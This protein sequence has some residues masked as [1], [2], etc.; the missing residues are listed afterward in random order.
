[1]RAE[2]FSQELSPEEEDEQ[3]IQ[4]KDQEKESLEQGEESTA[5]EAAKNEELESLK[6][7]A[8]ALEKEIPHS[9]TYLEEEK[10]TKELTELEAKI[11]QLEG[12]SSKTSSQVSAGEPAETFFR[13]EAEGTGEREREKE[14][15]MERP[16]VEEE[17]QKREKGQE[18]EESKEEK[19]A[20]LEKLLSQSR[21]EYAKYKEAVGKPKT[22]KE[23][24]ELEEFKQ[25]YYEAR[26]N[27]LEEKMREMKEKELG[28]EE[29]KKEILNLIL[30][31]QSKL[32]EERQRFETPK[33]QV[34]NKVFNNKVMRAYLKI[35]RKYRWV[36]MAALG[37]ATLLGGGAG[38]AAAGTYFG[39]KLSRYAIGALTSAG[40]MKGVEAFEKYYGTKLG[41][42][43]DEKVSTEIEAQGEISN[44][45]EQLINKT[46]EHLEKVYKFK[47]K[48]N[49]AKG[50]AGV[51]G[52]LAGYEVTD[53]LGGGV[54]E[55]AMGAHAETLHQTAAAKEA[56]EAKASYVETIKPG[57]S[58]WK[59][60][61]RALSHKMGSGWEHL[62]QAQKTY[63]IDAMK[64]KVAS[65][66]D[67]F[68]LHTQNID[69][70]HPGEKIDFSSVLNNKDSFQGI[71]EK[72]E[73]LSFDQ[74]VHI[75]S[76][77]D[78][79]EEVPMGDGSKVVF[80]NFESVHGNFGV[81]F[82]DTN[83]DGVAD[84]ALLASKGEVIGRIPFEGDPHNLED[85]ANF[86][87]N[88]RHQAEIFASQYPPEVLNDPTILK[89]VLHNP[90][91][92]P[93]LESLANVSHT[94]IRGA[95]MDYQQTGGHLELLRDA[96]GN[97]DPDQIKV[98]D[99][100]KG[101]PDKIQDALTFSKKLTGMAV[102]KK[103]AWTEL[104]LD[105]VK[106]K[107][108]VKAIDPNINPDKIIDS[109]THWEGNNLVMKIDRKFWFDKTVKISPFKEVAKH[110]VKTVTEQSG[111]NVMPDDEFNAMSEGEKLKP[112]FSES[113]KKA[114]EKVSG[115]SVKYPDDI[116]KDIE[117]V[118]M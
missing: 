1:M 95:F 12:E 32:V 60:A 113:A 78:W 84:S 16:T 45:V 66:P 85:I 70:I 18:K 80:S 53:L 47:K 79:H 77:V 97:W 23:K 13:N 25:N 2:A 83:H 14:E 98:L 54:A 5:Q 94:D 57:D 56:V 89:D 21:K 7:R 52:F 69:I 96:K 75:V 74:K 29:I 4:E 92:L 44:A 109:Q 111:T 26:K 110:S 64:D 3:E 33:H 63:L 46:D 102:D 40:A 106:Y 9:S 67:A 108:A 43:L 38:L 114:A 93:N 72:A 107:E 91:L 76:N 71:L 73:H 58:V 10:K 81:E 30:D 86:T 62:D 17:E 118:D 37:S 105:P 27:V 28:Q 65:N 48:T 24:E 31:E 115:H 50:L 8:R 59:A 99:S 41:E 19:E 6:E 34:L 90:K 22:E 36:G 39:Y 11:H 61:E 88:V 87:H 117:K 100:I 15:N 101:S 68:G 42:E 55:A 82:V 103:I 116:T 49:I 112:I 35:P 20:Q 104:H 51:A